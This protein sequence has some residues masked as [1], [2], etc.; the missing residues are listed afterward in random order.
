MKM[1]GMNNYVYFKEVVSNWAILHPELGDQSVISILSC[2]ILCA[3]LKCSTFNFQPDEEHFICKMNKKKASCMEKQE[4]S[5]YP[6][7][8]MFQIKV[9]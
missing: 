8:R 9:T 4:V 3:N 2:A 1:A 6:G 5:G 7:S